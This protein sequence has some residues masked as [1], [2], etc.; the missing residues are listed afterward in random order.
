MVSAACGT[1]PDTALPTAS[2]W[3]EPTT[4]TASR[5]Q[6]S[7]TAT[8]TETAAAATATATATDETASAVTSS[9]TP[10]LT[11]ALP[12]AQRASAAPR[13]SCPSPAPSRRPTYVDSF[14]GAG[15]YTELQSSGDPSYEDAFGIRLRTGYGYLDTITPYEQVPGTFDLA[16]PIENDYRTCRHC[17]FGLED[18]SGDH[19]QQLYLA[20]SGRMVLDTIN[21]DTGEAVGRVEDVQLQEIAATGYYAWEGPII[22]GRCLWID[23]LDFDTRAIPG[24][25]CRGPE[26][27]PNAALMTC[28]S[29]C[30]VRASG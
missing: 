16:D 8:T 4:A 27:C 21:Q 30:R 3:A 15:I 14:F 19:I 29:T 10:S 12:A 23:R 20:V 25:P 11:V 6:G 9:T 18:V 28:D 26:D 2:G 1:G 13:G 17:V 7:A 5:S 22:G 24:A